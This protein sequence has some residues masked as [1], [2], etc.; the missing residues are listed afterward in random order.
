MPLIGNKHTFGIEL[1]PVTPTWERR[2]APELGGWAG[3]AFWAGG[4]NLCQHLRPGETEVRDYFFVPVAPI[5]DWLVRVLPALE[6]EERAPSFPTT[7][8]L[9]TSADAWA[10]K[11]P[12][13]DQTE[14]Q[15]I[16]AREEWWTRHF[17]RAGSDGARL[18][19]LALVRDDEDLVLDWRAPHFLGDD[20]PLILHPSGDFALPWL[21]GRRIL[22][23]F[24]AE[25][26]EWLRREGVSDNFAWADD[27]DPLAREI[28]L[29]SALEW[30]TGREL[31]R[32]VALMKVDGLDE[33]FRALRLDPGS[34]DPASSPQCQILRD[35]SP[36]PEEGVGELLEEVGARI[37]TTDNSL[38]PYWR[39][40]RALSL[41]AARSATTPEEAG[42]NAAGALRMSMGLNGEPIENHESLLRRFGIDYAHSEVT[43]G[44]E[45]MVVG[46]KRDGSAT[47]RTLTSVR[48]TVRWGQRFEAL[49]ALGH[50]LLDPIRADAI[51]AA[52]GPF[53]QET[54]RRRSGAFAAEFLLPDTALA[55]ASRGELDG[56]ADERVFAELLE[57]YGVGAR[58]AA[59]QL[60][61]QNWLSSDVVRDELI[62]R[63]AASS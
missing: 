58:T 55:S 53:A 60:W 27:Q 16:D 43:G 23:D 47:A 21:D 11:S 45:R 50:V 62:D 30:Y 35:L 3:V 40:A 31:E 26:A 41:D 8:W 34:P 49:R 2:Y 36:T 6:F 14:D 61:N 20:A 13:S 59:Y 19:D 42:Y 7:R 4:T 10:S 15:W 25:I 18:P 1:L 48:T 57:R 28:D 33:L 46:L 37:A 32:L 22:G 52:S 51:G 63:F 24:I 17:L 39:D 5:S 12:P 56:A 38:S 44:H 54:R 29:R 9:H